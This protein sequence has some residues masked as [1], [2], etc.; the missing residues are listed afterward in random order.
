MASVAELFERMPEAFK[1]DK[2]GD[3][4]ATVQFDLSGEGGGQWYVVVANGDATVEQGTAANA[5]A[6]I[7]MAASD[8]HDMVTGKLNPMTAFIQQKVKV[9]GDLNTVMKFQTLFS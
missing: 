7:R 4:N 6:T 3:M 9:E 5:T 1:A 8:Y 2:A